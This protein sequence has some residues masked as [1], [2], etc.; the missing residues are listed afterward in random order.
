M[1][2]VPAMSF[3]WLQQKTQPRTYLSLKQEEDG[4]LEE[5]IS[6]ENS[7]RKTMSKKL[8]VSMITNGALILVLFLVYLDKWAPAKPQRILP[9][10]V[11]DCKL[12]S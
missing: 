4:R 3:K 12:L 7:R 8:L 9:S 11:P 5:N 6:P 1:F 2:V 10:P